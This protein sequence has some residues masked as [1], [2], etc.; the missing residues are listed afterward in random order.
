MIT[1]VQIHS[2]LQGDAD[3]P[4][5]QKAISVFIQGER[6]AGLNLEKLHGGGYSIRAGKEKRL[7]LVPRKFQEQ[8]VWLWVD[9]LDNHQYEELQRRNPAWW[10]A[11][12][13]APL[14]SSTLSTEPQA[15]SSTP[16]I[17]AATAPQ[18]SESKI[19]F[20]VANTMFLYDREWIFMDE[21]QIKILSLPCPAL[22]T[23]VP[24]AGK[25]F[26]AFEKLKRAVESL[27][28]TL[29]EPKRFLYVT[30]NVNLVDE[31]RQNWEEQIRLGHIKVP[32]NCHIEF[33]TTAQIARE[34]EG[35]A[36]QFFTRSEELIKVQ[37]L[38]KL[39]TQWDADNKNPNL[40]KNLP[41]PFDSNAF[42][43]EIRAMSGYRDFNE[44]RQAAGK[45]SLFSTEAHQKW[46]WAQKPDTQALLTDRIL[47]E[48]ALS[49]RGITIPPYDFIAIDETQLL[50][51]LEVALLKRLAKSEQIFY[52]SGDNQNSFDSRSNVPFIKNLHRIEQKL[53][54]CSL[55]TV[56]RSPAQICAAGNVALELM[57][58]I[59]GKPDHH[60]TTN[61]TPSKTAQALPGNVFWLSSNKE[62]QKVLSQQQDQSNYFAVVLPETFDE[63]QKQ[64]SLKEAFNG[65]NVLTLAQF[66]ALDNE[67]PE[68]KE[69][70]LKTIEGIAFTPQ[71]ITGL[72]FKNVFLYQPLQHDPRFWE[73]NTLLRT[74]S[75]EKKIALRPAFNALFTSLMR[76]SGNVFIVQPQEQKVAI[77]TQRCVEKIKA[78]NPEQAKPSLMAVSAEEKD[79]SFTKI[80]I[81]LAKQESVKQEIKQAMTTVQA[82]E[83]QAAK[84][85]AAQQQA[86]KTAEEAK[87]A[88]K[89][90]AKA[91]ASK[92][93]L[94][95]SSRSTQP[96]PTA[97]DLA[98]QLCNAVKNK[99]ISQI[100]SL[101]DKGADINASFNYKT[102]LHIA[103]QNGFEKI[104]ELLLNAGAKCDI[105]T[106]DEETPL[107][108]AIS[109]KHEKVAELLKKA[110]QKKAA[111]IF[112]DTVHQPDYSGQT[113]LHTAAICGN[114][115]FIKATL[116]PSDVNVNAVD[117]LN[118]TPLYLAAIHG[119]EKVVKTLLAAD[120]DINIAS[121]AGIT[122]HQAA[123]QQGHKKIAALLSATIANQKAT[124]VPEN[125]IA[126][127]S[128]AFHKPLPMPSPVASS[129][130]ATMQLEK[131]SRDVDSV[132]VI[133]PSKRIVP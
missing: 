6:T 52:V 29:E 50:W 114:T 123:I 127:N 102:P 81:D 38:Q 85:A 77:L 129:S 47:E 119:Q 108:L 2:K 65:K 96:M 24:G 41:M 13:E 92:A 117:N 37:C 49:T 115:H 18:A 66:R 43:Q 104:V 4:F 8:Q 42:Y 72:G 26:L 112:G 11:I 20:T 130:A 83:E 25:S 5:Y 87:R 28:D 80:A 98:K 82:Q 93:L 95:S 58:E 55:Q 126:T 14:T 109:N 89:Q 34:N 31:M 105:L 86:K 12:K 15:S 44:Y 63:T 78:L 99:N 1:Q 106:L 46:L 33:K 22:A 132:S 75:K 35:E 7:I 53:N 73:A 110:L 3:N 67:D 90:K 27:P 56:Y 40:K 32:K 113:P 97:Q 125:S 48:N 19:E 54:V 103:A 39:Q 16:H 23:G 101:L 64:A 88:S 45:H 133:G 79:E 118:Q 100:Q 30:Q 128:F 60:Q 57:C 21:E 121:H 36:F 131:D 68:T 116:L 9:T 124:T 70:K 62:L 122:P 61:I 59:T 10:R 51:N 111:S 91:T 107:D 17:S 120:A 69:A 71:E 84:A 76:S 94:A 74:K